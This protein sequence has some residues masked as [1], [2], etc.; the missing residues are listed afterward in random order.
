MALCA[1]P[2]ADFRLVTEEGEDGDEATYDK[3]MSLMEETN[4]NGV[5]EPYYNM[6]YGC[7][8]LD[9]SVL[10]HVPSI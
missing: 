6:G 3:L 8:F 2:L 9:R 5:L 1:R 10:S 7:Y 4:E